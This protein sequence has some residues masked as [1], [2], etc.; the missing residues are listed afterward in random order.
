MWYL[1]KEGI[2]ISGKRK[3][4]SRSTTT[5]GFAFRYQVA[6]MISL[7]VLACMAHACGF[8]VMICHWYGGFPRLIVVFPSLAISR[9]SMM[10]WDS[11]FLF[12][13]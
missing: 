7:L 2:R 12:F 5:M 6:C 4:T 9:I 1:E 8:L 11:F 10:L 3:R 13:G